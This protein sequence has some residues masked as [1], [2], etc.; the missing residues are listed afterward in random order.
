MNDAARQNASQVIDRAAALLDALA[1]YQE[2]VCLKVLSAETGLHASTTHRILG[3]LTKNRFV[4]RDASG[5]YRLGI[6]LLQ[7]GVRLHSNIDL[8]AVMHNAPTCR[9]TRAIRTPP[10][11]G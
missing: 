8:R 4:E 11:R 10:S 3:S 7:L 9:P 5:R 6:R 1:R 2:T